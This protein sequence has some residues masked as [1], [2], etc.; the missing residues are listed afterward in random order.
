MPPEKILFATDLSCRCDRALDRA[1]ELAREWKARL[2][3]C[4]ALEA[5]PPVID[6]PSWRR[7]LEP[8]EIVWQRI[9][10]DLSEPGMVDVEVIV[11]RGEPAPLVLDTAARLGCELIVTG[12]ARDET[13]G[14]V[15][16]GTTVESVVRR[17][18][19]PVLVVKARARR[20]YRDVMVASDFSEGSRKALVTALAMYPTARLSVFHAYQVLCEGFVDDKMS[21]RSSAEHQARLDGQ[22]FLADTPVPAVQRVPLLCEYGTPV[23]LLSE[24][25]QT[26]RVDLVVA[27]TRGRGRVAE[28]LLGSIAQQLLADVPGD[29]MVVPQA[30]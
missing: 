14:R 19:V 30:R 13:L 22:A 1:A 4:H 24:L 20:P 23:A 5:P 11:E 16:L 6:A 2:V 9:Y 25:M 29:V 3:V 12:V 17:S 21:A 7:P 10:A 8:K 28:L 27:G 15:L 26:G 18:K